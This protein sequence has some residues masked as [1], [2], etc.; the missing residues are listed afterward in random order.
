MRISDYQLYV[1]NNCDGCHKV[2][3]ELQKEN[4]EVRTVNIDQE[5]FNL[6]FSPI[7]LPALVRKNKLV[8]YGVNDIIK[9]LSG[10]H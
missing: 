2:M 3:A 1:S 8:G 10:I 7:I 6:P 9:V 4:I 5:E